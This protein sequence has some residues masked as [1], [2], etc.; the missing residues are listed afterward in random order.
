MTPIHYVSIICFF[1]YIIALRMI[2]KKYKAARLLLD[3]VEKA[4]DQKNVMDPENYYSI[5]CVERQTMG[6][7]KGIFNLLFVLGVIVGLTIVIYFLS[8]E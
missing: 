2:F 4:Y 8:Y 3:E 6:K 1:I 7:W 5:G